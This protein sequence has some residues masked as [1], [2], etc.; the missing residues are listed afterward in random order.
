[1]KKL[2]RI[3]ILVILSIS[4]TSCYYDQIEDVEIDPGTVI[5]F[6]D[7]IQPIFTRNNCI[8]CHNGNRDPDLR[9][10]N[11]Y[12]SLVPEY[13][14]AGNADDSF[15][16]TWL[17]IDGHGDVSTSDLAK[18]EAWINNGAPNN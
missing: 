7:D 16:Y 3:I 18:I 11:A 4:M 10:D 2:I 6:S 5:K 1:M 12:S 13:V 17:A 15:F 9:P 14:T 8:E